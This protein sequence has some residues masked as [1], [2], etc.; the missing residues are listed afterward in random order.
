VQD[1]L[2]YAGVSYRWRALILS[3][4]AEKASLVSYALRVGTRF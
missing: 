2:L 4:E 1:G 3:A